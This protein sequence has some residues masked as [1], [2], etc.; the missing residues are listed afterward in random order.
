MPV[1][2]RVLVVGIS[3]PLVLWA[4]LPVLSD[5]SLQG[6]QTDIQKTIK[7]KNRTIER[8]KGTERRLSGQIQ[9]YDNRIGSLQTRIDGLQTR[10]SSL[11]ADLDVKLG[12]LAA[13]QENLKIQRA[14]LVRLRARL[15]EG[16]KILAARLIELYKADDPDVM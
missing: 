10:E 11:P 16:R 5:A 14:R 15:A 7:R 6:K 4:V 12:Q 2:L 1:R 13:I 3:I 9:R 8:Q